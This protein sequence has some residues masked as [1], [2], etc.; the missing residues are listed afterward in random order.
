MNFLLKTVHAAS[1]NTDS[2]INSI[3]DKIVANI[4]APIL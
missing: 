2:M 3:V 4:V 1:T